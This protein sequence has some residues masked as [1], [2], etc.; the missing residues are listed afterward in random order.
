MTRTE[1]R[2]Q[3]QHQKQEKDIQIWWNNYWHKLEQYNKPERVKKRNTIE[4]QLHAIGRYFN[5][6]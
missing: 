3:E 2:I 6:N 4:K 5:L 1:K